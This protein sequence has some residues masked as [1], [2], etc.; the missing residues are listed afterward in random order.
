MKGTCVF[1]PPDLTGA[2]LL[3]RYRLDKRI[4]FGGMG[5]VYATNQTSPDGKPLAVKML[6]REHMHD[7]NTVTRFIEEGRTCMQLSHENIVRAFEVAVAENGS[8]FIV[9]EHLRGSPL[10]AYMTQ[11][12]R[13]SL[14]HCAAIVQGILAGLRYAHARGIVHRDLKPGNVFIA[15]DDS[16][17]FYVKLLDFGIAKVMD[18]ATKHTQTGALLGTPGYMSPEQIQSARNVDHRA[19]LYSVGVLAYEMLTGKP[20]YSAPTEYAKLAAVLSTH[21]VPADRIDPS[22][23]VVTPFLEKAMHKDRELRFQTAE[24]MSEALLRVVQGLGAGAD[25]DRALPLAEAP[26]VQRPAYE[27]TLNSG[28]SSTLNS[29]PSDALQAMA[30]S[31]GGTLNSRRSSLDSI[32]PMRAASTGTLPSNDIP[33]LEPV[34]RGAPRLPG[35]ASRGGVPL[36]LVALIAVI[37]IGAGLS[38]GLFLAKR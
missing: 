7:A 16:G 32:P 28:P 6:S 23:S 29:R 11:G 38:I 14:V 17:A 19:D 8:P 36:W 30:V 37:A 24:E 18:A 35:Q 33:V 22:L 1:E 34:G 9:L 25:T 3:G 26:S 15:K 4:G 27:A 10:G 31:P 20:A 13:M 2:V 5:D 12:A 21:P